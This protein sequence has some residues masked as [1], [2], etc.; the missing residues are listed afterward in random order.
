MQVLVF[1]FWKKPERWEDLEDNNHDVEG[2]ENHAILNE[3]KQNKI[4]QN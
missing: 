2:S 4:K 3:I 1:S